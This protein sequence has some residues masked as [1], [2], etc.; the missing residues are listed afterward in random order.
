MFGFA[1]LFSWL[2]LAV[3]FVVFGKLCNSKVLIGIGATM[4]L[5]M[6]MVSD[7]TC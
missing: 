2:G 7:V 3:I 6:S 4:L 5:M 1:I